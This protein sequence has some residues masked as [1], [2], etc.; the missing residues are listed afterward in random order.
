VC[1][2][3]GDLQRYQTPSFR[4]L[5]AEQLPVAIRRLLVDPSPTAQADEGRQMAYGL[6]LLSRL[7]AEDREVWSG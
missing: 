2:Q 6:F 7:V 4:R 5:F 3:S 1:R